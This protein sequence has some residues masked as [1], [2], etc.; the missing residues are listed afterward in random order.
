MS[1]EVKEIYGLAGSGKST[2]AKKHDEYAVL[3]L[4][5]SIKFFIFT[6]S[7]LA[8]MT[9]ILKNIWILKNP[10]FFRDLSFIYYKLYVI[11]MVKKH[12]NG[13]FIYDQ[14]P[15]YNYAFLNTKLNPAQRHRAQVYLEEIFAR[16]EEK[17]DGSIYLV[18]DVDTS[19][20]RVLNREKDHIYKN[21]SLKEAVNDL[22]KWETEFKKIAQR[23]SSER[24]ESNNE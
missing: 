13:A 2:Y 11:S 21:M 6:W 16:I 17:L 19:I 23:L 12:K 22:R 4:P 7:I 3:Q 9:A 24:V 10:R 1:S 5:K 14:G 8:E 20:T 18:C 15:L